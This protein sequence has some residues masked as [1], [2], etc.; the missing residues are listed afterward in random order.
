MSSLATTTVTSRWTGWLTQLVWLC[1]LLAV[2]PLG[3]P[4]VVGGVS[5]SLVAL[6]DAENDPIE[7]D[8]DDFADETEGEGKVL[9]ERLRLSRRLFRHSTPTDRQAWLD[10]LPHHH[11]THS[12][13]RLLAT[14][15]FV[16]G[17]AGLPLRC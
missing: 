17:V 15:P 11:T 4:A 7:S 13:F 12:G 9:T 5:T 1:C 16:I 2:L 14:S 6:L 8:E 10:H 3:T